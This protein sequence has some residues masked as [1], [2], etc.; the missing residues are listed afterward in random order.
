M[1]KEIAFF[2][3]DGTITSKDT[4]LEFIKFSKGNLRFLLGFLLNSP[5]LIAYK[6]KLISNQLAKEK[7]LS[8]FF[9]NVTE[10][11]FNNK[12]KAF[13]KAVLPSLIR[14]KAVEEIKTL[15]RKGCIVILVSA[16]PENWIKEWAEEMQAQLIASRLEVKDGLITGKLSGKNCHGQEKVTRILENHI[17]TEY[18]EIYAY[19]DTAGDMPMLQIATKTFFKPFR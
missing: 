10:V 13:S 14:P 7:I 8:F 12:C 3:F 15:Q 9:R 2:D 16:S 18:H 4:L 19:G 6:L 11:E 5:Y 17:L 1:K